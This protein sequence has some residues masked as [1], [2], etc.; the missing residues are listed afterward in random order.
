MELRLKAQ[1][2]LPPPRILL[3]CLLLA[4]MMMR[5][6]G[7]WVWPTQDCH[8]GL[9]S[10]ATRV[11]VHSCAMLP[12]HRFKTTH[13]S[14]VLPSKTPL[15]SPFSPA[16]GSCRCLHSQGHTERRQRSSWSQ[17]PLDSLKIH[18]RVSLPHC[19]VPSE[20]SAGDALNTP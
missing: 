9:S 20:A 10:E 18:I 3:Q 7:P 13:L 5:Q 11:D 17:S 19:T 6:G 15:G 1:E 4:H 8:L 12:S 16:L 2:G 14:H